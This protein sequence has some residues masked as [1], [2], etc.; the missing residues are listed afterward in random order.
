[1]PHKVYLQQKNLFVHLP[2]GQ[3]DPNGQLNSSSPGISPGM[4]ARAAATALQ[5]KS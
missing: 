2:A 5:A 4:P 1:M 3:K